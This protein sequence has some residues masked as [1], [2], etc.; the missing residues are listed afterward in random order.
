MIAPEYVEEQPATRHCRRC[1]VAINAASARCPY[2]GA[3]QYRRQPILGWRGALVCLVA[4]AAAVLVTRQIVEAHPSPASFSYYRSSDVALLVPA[5]YGNL[6]LAAPH[7]TALVSFASPSQP[8]DSVTIKATAGAPGT[9]VSRL[10]ALARQLRNTPGVAL[11]YRGV[12]SIV[13]PGGLHIPSL[14]YTLDGNDLAVFGFDS[15]RHTIGVTITLSTTTRRLLAQLSAV[16][17]QSA[18]AI[19]DGPR[20]SIQDRA[21]V[22]IP[23]ALPR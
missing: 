17:P 4:I 5:G 7:G 21:D 2:C 14:Y 3:R 12:T 16:V 19:C 9:P 13:L 20:F 1:D 15:C 6:Y 8:G 22:A 11:S 18:N 10:R 23:L